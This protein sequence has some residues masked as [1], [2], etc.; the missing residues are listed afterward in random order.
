[1]SDEGF[2]GERL[3]PTKVELGLVALIAAIVAIP[4]VFGL[5]ALVVVAVVLAILVMA[6]LVYLAKGGPTTTDGG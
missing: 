4:L 6:A 3:M 5:D 1:M 2:D